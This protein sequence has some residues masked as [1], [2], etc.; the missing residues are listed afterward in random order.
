VSAADFVRGAS[1][2]KCPL[3][4]Q[5]IQSLLDRY[6][7]AEDKGAAVTVFERSLM[8]S[9]QVFLSENKHNCYLPEY[10]QM[11]ALCVWGMQRFET[12]LHKVYLTCSEEVMINR[13]IRRGRS[14]EQC[15]T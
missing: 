3:Q 15:L 13:V 10:Y 14:S 8:V 4:S 9:L 5:V 12:P 1:A 2:E 6:T 11:E 7:Y